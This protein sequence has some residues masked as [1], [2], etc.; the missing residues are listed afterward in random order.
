MNYDCGVPCAEG[1]LK[2][3]MDAYELSLEGRRA[4]GESEGK[5]MVIHASVAPAVPLPLVRGGEV[6]DP[7]MPFLKKD[8]NCCI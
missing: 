3:L 5:R 6:G 1:L 7:L 2:C 4:R 8:M